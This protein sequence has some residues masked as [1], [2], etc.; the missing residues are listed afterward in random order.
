MPDYPGQTGE[1]KTREFATQA[2]VETPA[3]WKDAETK[4]EDKDK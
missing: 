4:T 1:Q 3:W 2:N